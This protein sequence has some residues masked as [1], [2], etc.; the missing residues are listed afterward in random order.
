MLSVFR[1][2]TTLAVTMAA[3]VASAAPAQVKSY[4]DIKFSAL[5]EFKIPKPEI[6]ELDN[7]MKVFLLEDHELPLIQVFVR[8]RTG[9]VYDPGDKTGLGGLVGQLQR[10]GGTQAMSGDELNDFLAVRAASIETGMSSDFGSASM[11]V[12]AEDFDEVFPVFADVLRKPRFAEDKL[13]VAKVQENTSISRRND[14]IGGITGREFN[15][16]IYGLDS[17]LSRLTEYATIAAIAKDDLAAWHKQY[18]HP[19]NTSLGI[20]GDFDTAA[21]KTKIRNAFG[22]WQKGTPAALPNVAYK[23]DMEPGRYF[24]EKSDVEQA[25]VRLGHLG[26]TVDN[27]DYFAAQVLNEVFGGGFSSRLFSTVR[28]K[29]GLAYSVFGGI[30]ASYA[31]QGVFQVGLS[32]KSKTMAESVRALEEEIN[33]IIDT[34]P[35]EAELKRAKESIL[36]SFVFNYDSPSEVL[37]QQMLYSYY[38]LPAD[39]LEKYRSSIE[40]VT[41][42]QV[43]AV[44][45]KYIHPDKLTLLVVGKPADFDEPVATFGAVTTIDIAIAPPAETGAAVEMTAENMKRGS[46]L[47][48]EAAKTM[49]GNTSKPVES[50]QMDAAVALHMGGQQIPATQ[51][52]TYSLPD[53]VYATMKLPMGEQMVVVNGHD[54]YM[55]MGGQQ[56]ALGEEQIEDMLDQ[57]ERNVLFLVGNS[58][59]P[60][61]RAAAAGEEGSYRVVAVDF[62]GTRSRLFLDAEGRVAK[63]T[64]QGKHPF[65]RA[66]GAVELSFSDFRDA[67]GWLVP[68]K[69]VMTVDGQEVLSIDVN[70]LRINPVVDQKL[71]ALKDAA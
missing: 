30:G 56:Q 42:E 40:S 11:N 15:R 60:D 68:H 39:F 23:K 18:Y 65:T 48:A 33:R 28:S 36:N 13:E 38:G 4:K 66:P 26:M 32:T 57:M 52:I 22:D 37:S 8:V 70:S 19:N 12:L 61:L 69:H 64:F 34:P 20:V 5:P 51:N 41:G 17:P 71:F 2:K 21:M 16:L 31:R 25:Y 53:K 29:K 63:Q 7:G 47:L 50:L 35:D 44:A 14:D 49:S 46:A 58:G 54:G 9:S 62:K 45:K 1:S 24:I 27:P 6:Y 67:D 43:A 3:L 10:E 55:S 59:N